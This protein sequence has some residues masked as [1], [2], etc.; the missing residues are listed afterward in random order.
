V[1]PTD[2]H[3]YADIDLF[4]DTATGSFSNPLYDPPSAGTWWYGIHVV[5]G[6]GKWNDEQ[7]SQTNGVPDLGPVRVTVGSA[8]GP[9]IDVELADGIHCQR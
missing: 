6:S 2:A 5:D 7:N 3:I 4:T 1:W 9:D 8:S